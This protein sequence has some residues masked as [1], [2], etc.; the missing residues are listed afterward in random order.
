MTAWIIQLI[1]NWLWSPAFFALHRPWLAVVVI[2]ALDV[3]A[4]VFVVSAWSIDATAALLFLPYVAWI[5]F[6]TVLNVAIA[7]LN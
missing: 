2:A 3:A 4:V 5:A 1:L 6:A 7:R